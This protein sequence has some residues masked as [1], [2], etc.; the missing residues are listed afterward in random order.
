LL[1]GDVIILS[2]FSPGDGPVHPYSFTV[3]SLQVNI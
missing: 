2:I 3:V 1:V